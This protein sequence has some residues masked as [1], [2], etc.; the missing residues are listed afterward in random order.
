MYTTIFSHPRYI[1]VPSSHQPQLTIVIQVSTDRTS[2]VK[3]IRNSATSSTRRVYATLDRNVCST[4]LPSQID[5]INLDGEEDLVNLEGYKNVF[6]HA[7]LQIRWEGDSP[8]WLEE[9][10]ASHLIER[11][12]G[13]SMY[14]HAVAT[15]VPSQVS[16]LPYWVS[17][18][19]KMELTVD[20]FTPKRYSETA[21][22][23]SVDG[24]ATREC[25]ALRHNRLQNL[26][27]A[28]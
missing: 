26:F 7:V 24:S 1:L 25:I 18:H 8:R 17:P 5:F 27:I 22:P 16:K 15:L 12:N 14:I 23:A 20:A 2:F 11:I 4:R 28:R 21:G 9:L 6:P 10:N 13:F 19:G 3:V